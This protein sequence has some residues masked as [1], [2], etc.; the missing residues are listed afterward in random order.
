MSATTM[1]MAEFRVGEVLSRALVILGRNIA[2]FAL[3]VLVLTLP[4]LYVVWQIQPGLGGAYDMEQLTLRMAESDV[5]DMSAVGTVLATSVVVLVVYA[6]TSSLAAGAVVYGT[7]QQLRGRTA[8]IGECVARGF[9]SIVPI[10][11]VALVGG[12]ASFLGLFLFIVPGIMLYLMFWVAVP[13]AVVERPGIFAS[14]RRSAA[15]TKGYRWRLL[16]I[17]LVLLVLAQVV[18][19]IVQAPFVRWDGSR[20][21]TDSLIAMLLLGHVAHVFFIALGAVAAAVAYYDLRV[22]K[23]GFDPARIAAIFD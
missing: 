8:G 16:G 19:S 4:Y 21:D 11:G 2:P 6:L 10:V 7:F 20:A 22:V 13:A 14:L 12:I 17:V 9:G 3:I 23:E 18:N 15:L 5:E 1:P